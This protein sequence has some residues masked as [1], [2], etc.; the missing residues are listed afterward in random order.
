M[1]KPVTSVTVLWLSQPL[2]NHANAIPSYGQ[3]DI[4]KG[5]MLISSSQGASLPPPCIK[6][7]APVLLYHFSMAEADTCL[8]K[9]QDKWAETAFPSPIH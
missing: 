7:S 1:P 2:A 6:V 8:F 3:D 4:P 5:R 9:G